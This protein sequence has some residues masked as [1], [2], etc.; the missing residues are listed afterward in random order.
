MKSQPKSIVSFRNRL[1][2]G[3]GFFAF[4]FANQGIHILAV[5]YYQMTL[6][7]NP[8]LLSI[9]MTAPMLI[10]SLL[11]PV[12]GHLSDNFHSGKLGKRRPFILVSAWTTGLCYGLVWMVPQHWSDTEQLLYFAATATL[13][14]L[15]ATFFTVPLN[16]LAFEIT[17]DY[18]QRTEVMGFTAYFLKL[19]SLLYQWVFPLAQISLFASV[20]IGVQ[21]VGWGLAFVVFGVC[22]MMPA[23]LI[24]ERKT[25]EYVRTQHDFLSSI[26][27]VLKNPSM[28]LLIALTLMLMGGVAFAA[29]MDYYLLVYYVNNGNITEGAIWK[30]VLSTAFALVS[31]A[32]VPLV[33]RL[34][35][36]RGKVFTLQ[37]LLGVN[38]LGG[39]AKWFIYTP[40]ARWVIV[41]DAILCG[42]IWTAMVV[43]VPSMIADLSHQDRE[44]NQT[45]RAGMYASVHAWVISFSSVLAFLLSGLCLW[46]MGFDAHLGRHQP[47]HSILIMR[48]ILVGGTV[49]F[50][51]LP[52]LMFYI[53]RK[54]LPHV[55]APW[56]DR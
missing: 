46:L 25:V 47:E 33:T 54:Q 34:S 14:Y 4:F 53:C 5:P 15:S 17:D 28:V 40:G 48:I 23:L 22:G 21:T 7:V 13:F 52:L 24:Q 27:S 42:A 18:H 44:K 16:G 55:L 19:G 36:H 39:L 56:S 3:L 51:V 26:R 32:C 8:F 49:F 10:G 20:I 43:L 41:S 38:M 9:A 11:G 12:V 30:G 45:S 37:V 6:G 2:L 35:F 29:T 31:M 50:S 1:A